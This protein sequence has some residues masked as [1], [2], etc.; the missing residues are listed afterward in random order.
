MS[1][2][3]PIFLKPQIFDTR[4]GDGTLLSEF[5]VTM[6]GIGAR[7][8]EVW[9]LSDHPGRESPIL[10]DPQGRHL[11]ELMRDQG[12]FILGEQYSSSSA[13]P[14]I[15]KFLMVGGRL[16]VQVHPDGDSARR[17]QL[18][19]RGKHE[20]WWIIGARPQA[21]I[22]HGLKESYEREQIVAAIR[23]NRFQ[24][25][26]KHFSPKQNDFLDIPPGTFHA[27]GGGLVLLE[28]QERCDVTLR[29]YDWGNKDTELH[30]D[31]AVNVGLAKEKSKGSVSLATAPFEMNCLEV[32]ADQIEIVGDR[33]IPEVIVISRGTAIL[34]T[35]LGE[36][37]LRAGDT[38]LW[39]AQLASG[40]IRSLGKVS[41]LRTFPLNH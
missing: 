32:D 7:S 36:R 1:L 6:P 23:E 16:S 29:V 18:S 4:W 3:N 22:Y 5:G 11:G 39:P 40:K 17:M 19:D 31:N 37:E 26:L 33:D 41:I 21:E 24:E 9:L 15:V 27:G 13:F 28:V 25:Y 38:V 20:A 34:E 12:A 35:G 30:V 14:L 10:D 2:S 8:G